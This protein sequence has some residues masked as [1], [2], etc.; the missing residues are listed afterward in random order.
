[1]QAEVTRVRDEWEALAQLDPMWAILT[2]PAKA[3]QAWQ[4]DEFF[5]SGRVEIADLVNTLDAFA[6]GRAL[7]RALDFGCGVGRLTQALAAHY[8]RVDGVDVSA[9]M[10][11]LAEAFNHEPDRCRYH[12]NERDDLSLFADESFDLIYT[13]MVLQHM[14]PALARS[15]LREFARCTKPRGL[16]A[17]QVPSRRRMNYGSLRRYAQHA[18]YGV[19]PMR[20]VRGYRRWKNRKGRLPASFI[21]N[22]PKVAMRMTAIAKTDVVALLRRECDLLTC[23]TNGSEADAFESVVY[24]FRKR[25]TARG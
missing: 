10:V 9:S 14:Q 4:R 5:E 15:Y 23:W 25:A 3:G 11:K 12:L 22:L 6:A 1:M 13:N 21:D 19:L 24:V 7:D 17:F 16:I 20:A 8:L 2:S 18:I